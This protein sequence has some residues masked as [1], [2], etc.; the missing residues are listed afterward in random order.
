MEMPS[1]DEDRPSAAGAVFKRRAPRSRRKKRHNMK[2]DVSWRDLK[3]LTFEEIECLE[4]EEEART[5]AAAQQLDSFGEVG[6]DGAAATPRCCACLRGDAAAP[7][8]AA[9]APKPAGGDVEAAASTPKTKSDAEAYLDEFEGGGGGEP[10]EETW[11]EDDDDDYY[12]SESDDDDDGDDDHDASRHTAGEWWSVAIGGIANKLGGVVQSVKKAAKDAVKER[13]EQWISTLLDNFFNQQRRNN[14]FDP[15]MPEWIRW[16]MQ[17][18]WDNIIP[19]LD[20]EMDLM[21]HG[22]WARKRAFLL[23]KMSPYDRSFWTRMRDPWHW[24]ITV[25][26]ALPATQAFSFTLY[27]CLIDK[28]DDFQLNE[29]IMQAKGFQFLTSGCF[30]MIMYSLRL[31]ACT[32]LVSPNSATECQTIYKG[33][34]NSV[35][36]FFGVEA[37]WLIDLASYV[38]TIAAN[39]SLSWIALSLM[40]KSVPKGAS[41]ARRTSSAGRRLEGEGRAAAAGRRREPRRRG[42]RAGRPA[43]DLGRVQTSKNVLGAMSPAATMVTEA[44]STAVDIA[45]KSGKRWGTHKGTVV[46]YDEKED[47]HTIEVE[48]G[49][50]LTVTRAVMLHKLPYIM[51]RP[52]GKNHL[53]NLLYWDGACAIIC[54]V[55]I[56]G[57]FVCLHVGS[58]LSP[59]GGEGFLETWQVMAGLFWFRCLY[60]I[61]TVPFLL[62][63]IPVVDKILGHHRPTAYTR[64]GK[65]VPKRKLWP[66]YP[67]PPEERAR[68]SSGAD[69]AAAAADAAGSPSKGLA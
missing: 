56:V 42:G 60:S 66:W 48:V 40:D 8:G 61:T 55:L 22:F 47:F 12:S 15:Q 62:A 6:D 14:T 43:K 11:S 53:K 35:I 49:D 50:G 24:I 28:K 9:A 39:I 3:G 26:K 57:A 31:A 67:M 7:A 23:Y 4:A 68:A 69:S 64:Y 27:L 21:P 2:K 16:R 51:L 32:V 36:G 58:P 38:W 17:L 34:I 37:P 44:A 25:F 65:C 54:A 5:R 20:E 46:A 1:I 52:F 59:G 30:T 33:S 63:R 19:D 29:F 41:S 10:R 13:G 45:T 18:V